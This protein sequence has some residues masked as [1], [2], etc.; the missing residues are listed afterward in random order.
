MWYTTIFEIKDSIALAGNPELKELHKKI[1][2][3]LDDQKNEW[4]KPFYPRYQGYGRIKLSG[5]RDTERRMDN[6]GLAKHLKHGWR[7]LDIG[8]NTGFMSL[9]SARLV[10]HV[11]AFD[12]NPYLVKIGQEV[13]DFLKQDNVSFSSCGFEDF[14]VKE[15]YDAI[16]SFAN[17]HTLDGLTTFSIN[18]YFTKASDSLNP[19]GLLFF[20]SHEYGTENWDEVDKVL[21]RF[22]IRME[23]KDLRKEN[24]LMHHRIL[25]ILKKKDPG[26]S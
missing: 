18:D 12:V 24:A 5:L 20:E 15:K 2:S 4:N 1:R 22:F 26:P 23:E 8:C 21:D 11:D 14:E 17:H 9:E 7:L 19:G 25:R 6:Y 10:R 16:F 3:H 13:K